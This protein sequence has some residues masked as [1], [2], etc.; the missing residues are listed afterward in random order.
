MIT[1]QHW[2]LCIFSLPF[3]LSVASFSASSDYS[4]ECVIT[5]PEATELSGCIHS[6]S[7]IVIVWVVITITNCVHGQL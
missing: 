2:F 7:R 4:S 6:V 5:A 3:L 1:I